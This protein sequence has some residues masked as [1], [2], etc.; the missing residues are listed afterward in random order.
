MADAIS[1][2]HGHVQHPA[3]HAHRVSSWAL[4]AALLT[5]PVVWFFQL[6]ILYG[7]A[8][9]VCFPRDAP[10]LATPAGFGWLTSALLAINVVGLALTAAGTFVSWRSWRLTQEEA[11]GGHD[12][13][14]D[15]GEGR[16]RFLSAWG[17]WGG[18]WFLIA[19]LFDTIAVL[20]VPICGG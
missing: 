5:G 8:G 18:S 6:M 10:R 1:P 11:R 14:L 20:W 17:L 4:C 2:Q 3:P 15:T 7:M 13:L 9:Q 19:I 16:T 12:T